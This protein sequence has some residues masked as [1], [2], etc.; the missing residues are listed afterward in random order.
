MAVGIVKAAVLGCGPAGLLAAHGIRMAGERYGARV[1]LRIYS[2]KK[3]SPLYGCQ[4]LHAPVPGLG[5][6]L[7]M[8]EVHYKLTGSISGYREKVYGLVEDVAVSPELLESNHFAWN[9]RQV[10]ERLWEMYQPSINSLILNQDVWHLL[11][12]KLQ[13]E[14]FNL[15]VTTVPAPALCNPLS[16]TCTFESQ[17]IWAMGDAPEL[18]RRVP[19]DYSLHDATILCSGKEEDSWYR[20]SN[21]FGHH[22]IEWPEGANPLRGASK[23]TKPI[24]TNCEC[25]SELYRSGRFARWE[26]GV[27]AH[28]SY[29]DGYFLTE[30]LIQRG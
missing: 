18:G 28:Q 11:H 25:N 26:K 13:S 8:Q 15:L 17:Q 30:E 9:I 6:E 10:Y 19:A 27:L 24:K 7:R 5:V 29:F 4:Y 16:R 14:N 1:D 23:V 12:N 21:V 2:V 22:T 20:I 3:K